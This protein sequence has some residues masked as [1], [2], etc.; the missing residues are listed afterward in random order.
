MLFKRQN[1][2]IELTAAI[3][4]A[5]LQRNAVIKV[6]ID[7]RTHTSKIKR[8]N[9]D[10]LIVTDVLDQIGEVDVHEYD[11]ENRT[12]SATLKKTSRQ[13]RVES[14]APENFLFPKDWHRQDLE[15]IPFCAERHV[16]PRSSLIERG[17]PKDKVDKIRRYGAMTNVTQDSRLP[18]NVSVGSML[19]IDKS[20][21]L[22]E[23]YECYVRLDDGNGASELH[24]ISVSDK[25]IL[26]DED[27]VSLICY[28][29]GVVIIN[30]HTFMGISSYDKL[31]S[32]QD[33]STAL[34]RALMDNLNA[35]NKNRT[36]H[37]DGVADEDDLTDGRH[38]GSIRVKPGIV[39]DV[40]MAVAAFQVPDTSANILAN[41]QHMRTV[42]SEMGGAALDLATGQMQLNDRLG[43]Q[44]LDRAYSVMERH[45]AF[46]TRIVAN[47][48]VRAMYLI[49]HETLRTQWQGPISFQRGKDWIQQD[50]SKWQ[51]RESVVINLGASPGERA[52][53]SAVL[54]QTMEVQ[55][56]LAQH[57]MEDILV[58]AEGYY[59]AAIDWLR[60]N[61]IPNPE[62]YL[63]NPKTPASQQAFKQRAIMRQMQSQKQ[64][65]LM[66]QA[67]G[68]EQLRVG[69]Q[70]Y[71]GDAELQFK[72]YNAVLGAQVEEAKITASSVIDYL[73]TKVTAATAF[74]KGKSDGNDTGTKKTSGKESEGES[75][76]GGDSDAA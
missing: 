41:L 16:E 58:N 69:I 23:W 33:S 48:L 10:P 7:E 46:M 37:F 26:E 56:A 47:T 52:R 44:G 66:R 13:F 27:D 5:M 39:P 51:V 49:A 35:T 19:N 45:A 9:V 60:I 55:A 15:G 76:T 57:G 75:I 3:K 17:F 28:A 29:T 65:A 11:S 6:Y 63:L 21:E 59:A 61:D 34:T 73:K 4:D 68:L 67:V 71:L 31:K 54:Q 36:A 25:D 14:I 43:S 50:P 38:N 2:Y 32:T 70:K 40:R 72:Y 62:R 53:Q 20:Q 1:G 42:R 18:R 74:F 22:V 12:L 24:C 64:D 8:A 30:P